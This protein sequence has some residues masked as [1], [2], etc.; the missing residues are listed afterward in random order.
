MGRDDEWRA[1]T[2]YANSEANV[3]L[4]ICGPAGVGKSALL[5]SWSSSYRTA[6]SL[7]VTHF[8]GASPDS[9]SAAATMRR[10]VHALEPSRGLEALPDSDP[11]EALAGLRKALADALSRVGKTKRIIVAI[12][13]LERIESPG[14]MRP[15]GWLPHPLPTGVR[16]ILSVAEGAC[17][18][19]LRAR[20]ARELPLRPLGAKAHREMSRQFLGRFGK[21]LS[22]KPGSSG[23]A[24]LS[25]LDLFVQ[26]CS[27][28]SALYVRTALE[29]LRLIARPEERVSW[30]RRL[31][32]TELG[33]FQQML[34][35]S[36]Q[37]TR[38]CPELVRRA[39]GLL[40]VARYGLSENELRDLLGPRRD[41][42]LPHV[43]WSRI[44]WRFQPY[45]VTRG[46]LLNFFDDEFRRAVLDR[47]LAEPETRRRLHQELAALFQT[48]P[49]G[50]PPARHLA[51][52]VY[53]QTQA[54]DW[55]E[56]ARTVCRLTFVEAK[57]RQPGVDELREDC[58]RVLES[59]FPDGQ[60]RTLIRELSRGL[61]L[62]AHR[63]RQQPAAFQ[64][65]YNQASWHDRPEGP[66]FRFLESWRRE[67]E[68]RGSGWICS[69]WP[70]LTA[71][72]SSLVCTLD[73]HQAEITACAITPD[74]SRIVSG[75][76]DGW[77]RVWDLV[78]GRET[79]AFEGH[80]GRITGCV[81][82]P[83]EQRMI[84][85]A[86]DCT[87]KVW[88]LTAGQLLATLSGHE[89][90]IT[91]CVATPDGKS[92]ISASRDRTLRLWK[93]GPGLQGLTFRGHRSEVTAC[94]VAPDG[95]RLV[96]ASRDETL[97]I[98]DL[99]TGAELFTL[100]EPST[101]GRIG[102]KRG[103][104]AEV[105]ACAVTPDGRRIVS[106]SR[107]KT[108]KLWDT[109]SGKELGTLEG[110]GGEVTAIAVAPD[111]DRAVSASEDGTLR[112]WNLAAL[113][114]LLTLTGHQ[115]R[116]HACLVTPDG[117]RVVSAS[118]DR[119]LKVWDLATGRQLAT[120]EG[121]SKD[122]KTTTCI[123]TPDGQRLLSAD[124]AGQ[125]RLWDLKTGRELRVFTGHK[126]G[127][128]ACAVSPSSQWAASASHDK[129]LMLWRLSGRSEGVSLSGHAGS[130]MACAFTPGGDRVLSASADSTLRLWEVATHRELGKLVGHT[131]T[132]TD[133]AV[134]SG[135]DRAISGSRDRTVRV[136]DLSS[137]REVHVLS[138]HAAEVL[139]CAVTSDGRRAVSASSD[140]L[141]K[142]WDLDQGSLVATLEGH[143]R[144]VNSLS[145]IQDA[146]RIVS[147]S[148]DG[149][150]RLW[151]LDAGACLATFPGQAAFCCC[152]QAP[153]G[154]RLAAG[155]NDGHVYA[156][157]LIQL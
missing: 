114:P 88:D 68:A 136:W 152:A 70:P 14:G 95:F 145:L 57:C 116:V 125:L 1:L 133:C 5:A 11:R 92:L 126:A 86:A 18:E 157:E 123:L 87:L 26:G 25:E 79:L 134:T 69:L 94:A 121:H 66:L 71:L 135:G 13:A 138:G 119:T 6:N 59:R 35:Q 65:L 62:L 105:V 141:L 132:V 73:G 118:R 131:D 77:I 21:R 38:D 15:P 140:G 110:H 109:A 39:M 29:E 16:M 64:E 42:R 155:D 22:E 54:E 63:L 81:C 108:L 103:H 144:R 40:A 89:D 7:V 53:H 60:D 139:S 56:V 98:W 112:I 30:I 115:S 101:V 129:T 122:V 24:D 78:K 111:G 2:E 10:L 96:S 67:Y 130:V 23:E 137:L 106:A 102:P 151:D 45:L 51:E 82:L 93:L 46:N 128:V 154:R 12:D 74:G 50:Q 124:S 49:A 48:G 47:Y 150:L 104:K 52:L 83:D 120:L 3:P 99:E 117:R 20:G 37:D 156:I 91:A 61:D 147:A 36:E 9:I 43:L 149:T 80:Q 76:S 27:G 28:K 75:A 148:G 32:P 84:S 58:H 72:H 8:A 41:Q 113:L 17:L 97:R 4:V 100:G 34:D 31:P 153:G 85:S 55:T 107:D 127:V 33:L 44:Y 146:R 142:L 90:E 19:G 143:M